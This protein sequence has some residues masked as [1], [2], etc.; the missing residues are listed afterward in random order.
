MLFS[1]SNSISTTSSLEVHKTDSS[2]DEEM[3][4]VG[5]CAPAGGQLHAMNEPGSSNE[6]VSMDEARPDNW[7]V[8]RMVLGGEEASGSEGPFEMAPIQCEIK[9]ISGD[10]S[11]E[12]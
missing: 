9:S 2:D 5:V 1:C 8:T 4:D 7:K 3:E 6:S 11:H 10:G 12:N